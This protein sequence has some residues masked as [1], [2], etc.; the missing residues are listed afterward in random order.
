MIISQIHIVAFSLFLIRNGFNELNG[1]H[2]AGFHTGLFAIDSALF[3]PVR[4]VYAKV[5]LG[6]FAREMVPDGAVRLLGAHS[7]TG[8]AADAFFAVNS[9]DV[10]IFGIHEGGSHRAILNTDGRDTLPA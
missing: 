3:I 10:A 9:S 2:R 7:E 4:G 1:L 8:F 5:A 6:G